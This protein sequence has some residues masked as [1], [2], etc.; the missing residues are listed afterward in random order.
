MVMMNYYFD[1]SDD[2]DIL[3]MSRLF[4]TK[5]WSGFFQ[6]KYSSLQDFSFLIL[7]QIII[8]IIK[9]KKDPKNIQIPAPW[10][11]KKEEKWWVIS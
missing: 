2:D 3:L 7:I 9:I 5:S 6:L 11:Q 4:L 8:I 1:K 10:G